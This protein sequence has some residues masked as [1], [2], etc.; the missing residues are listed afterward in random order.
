MSRT[1]AEGMVFGGVIFCLLSGLHLEAQTT[2]SNLFNISADARTNAAALL[3]PDQDY[4]IAP[5]DVIAI[6]VFNESRLTKDCAVQATGKISYP[7]LGDIEIAGKTTREVEALMRELLG[8][9]YL[10]DPV[11]TVTM[12]QYRLQT[13]NILGEV[14]KPGPMPLVGEKKWTLLDAISQAGGLTRGAA[15]SRIEFTRQGRT[16][17]IDFDDLKKPTDPGKVIY[18]QPDDVIYVPLTPW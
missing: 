8:K 3:A 10:V 7:L 14:F 15:K 13:V 18:L 12:K 4:R 9:D 16:I 2:P 6:D 1:R 17:K 5:L 11:V